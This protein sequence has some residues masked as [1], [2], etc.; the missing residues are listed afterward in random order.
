MRLMTTRLNAVA[1]AF[2]FLLVPAL[3]A[4]TGKTELTLNLPAEGA[5]ILVDGDQRVKRAAQQ[6]T[7]TVSHG[8]HHLRIELDGYQPV[9]RN[10]TVRSAATSMDIKMQEDLPLMPA[11]KV[12]TTPQPTASFSSDLPMPTA[13]ES[14]PA[15]TTVDLRIAV[16]EVPS[17]TGLSADLAT[18]LTS[19]ILEDTQKRPSVTAV[20]QQ[21]L[22]YRLTSDQRTKVRACKDDG[23]FTTLGF[24][25]YVDEILIPRVTTLQNSRL[26]TVERLEVKGRV[27]GTSTRSAP[28][29]HEEQFLAQ[30][31]SA[32][33]DLYT[34]KPVAQEGPRG[35]S[36]A[37]VAQYEKRPPLPNAVFIATGGLAV[38]SAVV[39]GVFGSL[40][41]AN[42]KSYND[43][44]KLASTQPISARDLDAYRS[45]SVSQAQVANVAFIAAGVL[46]VGAGVEAIFTNWS[47]RPPPPTQE[48]KPVALHLSP[49]GVQLSWR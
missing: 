23:C 28:I 33:D 4:A 18:A 38:V 24:N 31:V 21:D 46:A 32:L 16:M 43:S 14:A 41:S 35:V 3:A 11:E 49:G 39:G 45:Q 40:S 19:A 17:N 30:L 48:M 12:P 44:A 15:E 9:E 8:K 20:G 34:D 25:L 29:G 22:F 6:V 42:M 2:L 47:G 37:M 10:I 27:R 1:A 26:L 5:R 36:V 13:A 7:V